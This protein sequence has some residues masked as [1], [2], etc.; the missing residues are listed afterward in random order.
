MSYR[1]IESILP[2]AQYYRH[3]PTADQ[4]VAAVDCLLRHRWCCEVPADGPFKSMSRSTTDF[5]V[6]FD[7]ALL[8]EMSDAI[9]V[10][11]RSIGGL[12]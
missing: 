4:L 10:P 3:R 9:G 11:L 12:S 6:H 1:Y 7:P 8:A 5:P 2:E